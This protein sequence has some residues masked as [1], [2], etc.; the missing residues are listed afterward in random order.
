EHC[1]HVVKVATKRQKESKEDGFTTVE[2]R[3]KGKKKFD[4]NSGFKPKTNLQYKPVGSS[5]QKNKDTNHTRNLFSALASAST[6][7]N[8]N[9]DNITVGEVTADP[10]DDARSKSSDDIENVYDETLDVNVQLKQSGA[11]T[12]YKKVVNV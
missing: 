7:G 12:P 3:N 5:K 9:D 11:S 10:L 1:P 2:I 4:K 8:H 6:S